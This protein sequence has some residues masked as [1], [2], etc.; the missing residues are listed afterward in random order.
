MRSGRLKST[1]IISRG[2]KEPGKKMTKEMIYTPFLTTRAEMI[3]SDARSFLAEA[4]EQT[5]RAAVFRIRFRDGIEPGNRVELDG[6]VYELVEVKAVVPRRVLELR[7][8]G[9]AS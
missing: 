3:S 6:L 2:A 9:G 8:T 5:E 1:I 4:G 7:C